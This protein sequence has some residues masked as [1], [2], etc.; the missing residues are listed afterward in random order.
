MNGKN[1]FVPLLTASLVMLFT[2]LFYLLLLAQ[3]SE[4]LTNFLLPTRI[5]KKKFNAFLLHEHRLTK[6]TVRLHVMIVKFKLK[7]FFV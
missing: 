7:F 2:L 6:F 4:E 5:C 1:P 3:K